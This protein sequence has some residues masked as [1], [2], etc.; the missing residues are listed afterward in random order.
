MVDLNVP[1][2]DFEQ[3][4]GFLLSFQSPF[5]YESD[6]SGVTVQALTHAKGVQFSLG[7]Y[8]FRR[9][10]SSEELDYLLAVA[11]HA[12]HQKASALSGYK[13]SSIADISY[14][15]HEVS[16]DEIMQLVDGMIKTL[17]RSVAVGIIP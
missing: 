10:L 13:S 5:Q 15:K 11:T 14:T 4:N 2:R 7:S 8:V 1:N 12:N 3:V 9:E 17:R 16:Y 6:E